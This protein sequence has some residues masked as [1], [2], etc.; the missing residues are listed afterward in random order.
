MSITICRSYIPNKKVVLY[1]FV[2]KVVYAPNTKVKIE[3][4]KDLGAQEQTWTVKLICSERLLLGQSPQ[5]DL[6]RDTTLIAY[7]NLALNQR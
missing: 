7:I 1:F 6:G 2:S 5:F 4:V 3:Q